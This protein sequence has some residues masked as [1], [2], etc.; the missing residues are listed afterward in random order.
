MR[1]Y[2]LEIDGR[3]TFVV[4]VQD[5]G[6]GQY[7]IEMGGVVRRAVVHDEPDLQERVVRAVQEIEFP[8][9][10]ITINVPPQAPPVVNIAPPNVSI[11]VPSLRAGSVARVQR[12]YTG[13]ITSVVSDAMVTGE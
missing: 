1:Q 11:N 2:L 12:D 7:L 4:N 8:A 6:Q 3:Q 13:K 5:A 9:P 10:Q